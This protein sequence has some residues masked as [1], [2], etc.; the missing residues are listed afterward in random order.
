MANKRLTHLVMSGGGFAAFSY[1]GILRFLAMEGLDR[2]IKHISGC[3]MGAIFAG[4]V[5]LGIPL[6]VLERRFMAMFADR[7]TSG[8]PYPSMLTFFSNLGMDNGRNLVT[9]LE[10]EINHVTFLDLSKRTGIDLVICATHVRSMKAV[11]FSVDTTPHVLVADAIRASA[12]VPWVF[13]PVLIGEDYYIDGGVSANVPDAPFKTA[14]VPRSAIL[15]LHTYG[16]TVL[17]P[18]D[19]KIHDVPWEYTISL[20]SRYFTQVSGESTYRDQYPNYIFLD[21]SPLPLL[22]MQFQKEIIRFVCSQE[23]M[24]AC[25]EYGYRKAFQELRHLVIKSPENENVATL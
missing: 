2:S 8:I 4:G 13:C 15:V 25:I 6:D 11:F 24:D 22:N 7:K 12:A 23:E 21:D 10:P 16:K 14:D 9:M 19:K 20:V 1:F 3:S 5:A 18:E 17:I